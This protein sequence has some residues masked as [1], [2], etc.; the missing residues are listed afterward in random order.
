MRPK[1]KRNNELKVFKLIIS[2]YFTQ[3]SFRN[4]LTCSNVNLQ[5][6]EFSKVNMLHFHNINLQLACINLKRIFSI[7]R[8]YNTNIK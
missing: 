7:Q 4:I 2:R 5:Y 3:S 8:N 6:Y 1:N